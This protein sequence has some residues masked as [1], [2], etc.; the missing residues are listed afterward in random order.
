MSKFSKAVVF[1]VSAV[2]LVVLAACGAAATPETVTV[3]ETV[4]VEKIVE[5]EV[6]KEVE[7]EVVKTVR[8]IIYNSYN[9]DPD[10]RAFDEKLVQIFKPHH[11]IDSVKESF[12]DSAELELPFC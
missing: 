2:M 3:I 1:V 10:P 12:S 7:K 6:V 9:S 5:K 11:C 8:P 4:E